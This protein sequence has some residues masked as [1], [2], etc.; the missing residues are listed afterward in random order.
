[1]T[2]THYFHRDTSISVLALLSLLAGRV[3]KMGTGVD[4]EIMS[5]GGGGVTLCQTEGT[6]VFAT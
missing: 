3:R 2:I 1:M 5:V 6:R 4:Q